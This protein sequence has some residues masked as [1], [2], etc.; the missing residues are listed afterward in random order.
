[1]DDGSS[2]GSI[3]SVLLDLPAD[4]STRGSAECLAVPLTGEQLHFHPFPSL[5]DDDFAVAPG[6][7]SLSICLLMVLPLEG[8]NSLICRPVEHSAVVVEPHFHAV[9]VKRCH[10]LYHQ[11]DRLGLVFLVISSSIAA[12]NS[13]LSSLIQVTQVVTELSFIFCGWGNHLVALKC[14]LPSIYGGCHHCSRLRRFSV[15]LGLPY[16]K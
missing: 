7:E 2:C 8:R 4:S 9:T 16:R 3:F 10:L 13:L 14:A 11:R 5:Y 15:S 1:M 12:I 6:S